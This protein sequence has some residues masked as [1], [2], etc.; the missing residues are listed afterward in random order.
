MNRRD[1]L[2][3]LSRLER[4][5]RVLFEIVPPDRVDWAPAEGMMPIR[6]LL[7]HIAQSI[8]GGI[9]AVCTGQWQVGSKGPPPPPEH[10][11]RAFLQEALAE[12]D[13]QFALASA[14]VAAL[15]DAVY[16]NGTAT[17]PPP[18]STTQPVRRW[19]WSIVEHHLNHR[20][21]LFVY[22][23]ILGIP[24]DTALLYRGEWRGG[25]MLDI[26]GK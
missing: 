13:R 22:L 24:V 26:G 23:R 21:Q 1:Y 5:T 9:H 7:W 15:A 3:Y 25:E 11:G 8:G 4:L 17:A 20:M 12:L 6:L 10:E 14:D 16:E 18:L 2:E 19:L